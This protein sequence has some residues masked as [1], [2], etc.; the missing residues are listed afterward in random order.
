MA[1]LSE[2]EPEVSR[3]PRVTDMYW[4]DEKEEKR[5][6]TIDVGQTA[7]LYVLT[8][9]FNPDDPISVNL[10]NEETEEEIVLD[11]TVKENGL[12]KIKWKYES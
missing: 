5:I 4:M 11:G 10:K 2:L 6:E 9:D 8:E 1:V 12:S 3:N 7:V